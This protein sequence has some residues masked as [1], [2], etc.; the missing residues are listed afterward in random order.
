MDGNEMG[1]IIYGTQAVN[2][3]LDDT[4]F[5]VGRNNDQESG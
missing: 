3:G 5:I 2:R 1:R 4:D